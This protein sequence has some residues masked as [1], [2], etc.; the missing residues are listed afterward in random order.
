[1]F[2]HLLDG[3]QDK[4]PQG[5]SAFGVEFLG[6]ISTQFRAFPGNKP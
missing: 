5:N 1:M 2:W 6:E 3:K 4:D